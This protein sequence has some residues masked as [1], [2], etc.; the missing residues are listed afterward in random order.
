MC[1]IAGF[2]GNFQ[3]DSLSQMGRAIAHRGPDGYGI[4]F[5]SADGVGLVHRRLAIIDVSS[6][7][8]Q[9]MWSADKRYIIV[10]NGEI[11]NF[12][13]LRRR[14]EAKG[15]IFHSGSDT[16]V[17]LEG[18][19][20]WG[21]DV[22]GMLIGMFAF[23]IW[24]THEKRLFVAR[25]SFGVKPLYLHCSDKGFAFASELKAL[26]CVGAIESGIDPVA[27][28]QYVMFMYSTGSRTPLKAVKKMKP[29]HAMW[30]GA[31]GS[32]IRTWRFEVPATYT[33]DNML[34]LEEWI[35]EIVSRLDQAVGRQMVADVPVGTFL[36]GGLDSS[37]ITCF[38]RQYGLSGRLKSYTIGFEKA[39]ANR[40]GVAEDLPYARRVAQ[41]IGVD[42]TIVRSRPVI[43]GDWEQAIYHLDEP[44]GDP[45]VV[46][47]LAIARNA[48]ADGIKVLLSG[49]GGDDLFSGY[50]RHLAIS[51]EHYLTR[52]PK[53]IRTFL[54]KIAQ[55]PS[56]RVAWTRRIGRATQDISLDENSRLIGY[57][58]WIRLK[59]CIS[60]FSKELRP[61]IN[62]EEFYEEM[63]MTLGD[64]PVGTS[65]LNRMLH[66]DMKYFLP[67]HNLNYTDK[68]SMAAG[69]EV[70]VP[71]L[72]PGLATLAARI[73]VRYK[74]NGMVGKW[75][76]KR[77]AQPYL[78]S[79]VI[80]RPKS[81]FGAPLRAWME[82]EL[83]DY[84]RDSLSD[85]TINKRGVF[86]ATEIAEMVS[87]NNTG[88]EDCAY[89]LFAMMSIEAWFRVFYDE[90][91]WRG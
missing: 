50:R 67:D 73:P 24:D 79:E 41:H 61:L 45:A 82:G 69:V 16:E 10:F 57:F 87:R 14:L 46:N 3:E 91:R 43:A 86:D 34:S 63:L 74:Q 35:A 28:A 5:R 11:Y 31:N 62:L 65:P 52:M 20:E 60:A 90:K 84:V 71:F 2:V 44:Q 83:K 25:D 81:G 18:F 38:A 13:D 8:L 12:R 80:Y 78:P 37:I 21:E 85:A 27:L 32:V 59:N 68:M 4:F 88:T 48:R 15:R 40:E 1:G 17:L 51:M 22:L 72:D 33:E 7:G 70:R 56:K 55:L 76:L 19:G 58:A 39:H 66:L 36:S 29:G 9:P 75:I 54:E 47:A 64:L 23:A 49:A 89:P 6:A 26:C 42:L 30:I 77:A 53:G